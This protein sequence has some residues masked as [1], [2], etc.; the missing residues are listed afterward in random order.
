MKFYLR[1]IGLFGMLVA[2][3]VF[4]GIPDT[5]ERRFSRPARRRA[6]YGPFSPTVTRSPRSCCSIEAVG[7]RTAT[8]N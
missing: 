7:V 8:R 6:R 4:A 3:P 2:A 5:P 1:L